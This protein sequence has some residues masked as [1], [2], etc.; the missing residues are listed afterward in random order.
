MCEI[1]ASGSSGFLAEVEFP[2]KTQFPVIQGEVTVSH[3]EVLENRAA[4]ERFE[5]NEDVGHT[6]TDLYINF[7]RSETS[8]SDSTSWT[9]HEED[10]ENAQIGLS[11]HSSI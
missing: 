3:A 10:P 2:G 11:R 4:E 6:A 1:V 8:S 9:G 5:F 7:T